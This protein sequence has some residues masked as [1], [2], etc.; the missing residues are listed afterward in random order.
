MS[1]NDPTKAEIPIEAPAA[2]ADPPSTWIQALVLFGVFLGGPAFGWLIGLLLG[3]LSQTAQTL[4]YIPYVL[5][6]FAGYS[7]WMARLNALGFELL[8]RSIFKTLFN[9]IFRRKRPEKFEDVL[10]SK[11]VLAEY[12]LRALKTTSSFIWVALPIAAFSA[13]VAVFFNSNA[14]LFTRIVAV[15]SSCLFWGY[16]LSAFAKRG[17]LPIM[18]D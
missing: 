5:I 14:G 3:N 11:E 17:Y 6:L 8:G 9:L 2:F 1:P 10:P 18:E 13:L 12:A 15:G 7:V 4:L 16:I